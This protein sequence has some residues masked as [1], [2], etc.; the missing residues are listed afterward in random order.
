MYVSGAEKMKAE[1]L[2][3]YQSLLE[4]PKDEELMEVIKTGEFP[5]SKNSQ[6]LRLL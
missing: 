4:G 6:F 1:N 3:L 5:D 2:G